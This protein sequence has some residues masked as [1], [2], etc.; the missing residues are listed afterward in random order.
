M[1]P[2]L[3]GRGYPVGTKR[4]WGDRVMVKTAAGW[5][6][7]SDGGSGAN[8]LSA[9]ALG[10]TPRVSDVDD[11]ARQVRHPVAGSYNVGK[12]KDGTYGVSYSDE[13]PVNPGQFAAPPVKLGNFKDRAG[14]DAAINA[15]APSVA[16]GDAE[17]VA[18]TKSGK[19]VYTPDAELV[20]AIKDDMHREKDY[21]ARAAKLAKQYV[22]DVA[23]DYSKQDHVDAAHT[24]FAGE[25]AKG[26]RSAEAKAFRALRKEHEKRAGIPSLLVH[27]SNGGKTADLAKESISRIRN[28]LRSE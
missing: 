7:H 17:E 10:Y 20:G 14:V 4:T 1:Q 26:G 9:R 22:D 12:N 27:Y 16:F 3:E 21:T 8:K 19:P 24:M 15:H 6:V 23:S 5:V 18:T 28:L 25:M 11:V 13:K 2:F